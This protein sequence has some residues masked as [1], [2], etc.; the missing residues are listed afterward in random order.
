AEL[1]PAFTLQLLRGLL[2]AAALWAAAPP[3]A[4]FFA[5][6]GAVPVIRAL[7]LVAVLR[8]LANPAV[9]LAVR[10]IEFARVFWW[11][12][13]EGL[14]SF[15]LAV[16]VALIRRD[17]W[18]LV[19]AA[20]GMQLVAA[21]A[22]YALVP[23]RPRLTLRGGRRL[24]RFGGWVSGARTLMFLSVNADNAV[25]GRF[26]GTSALGIY[27]LAFRVS[28]LAVVTVAR[29]AGQVALPALSRLRTA[30]ERGREWGAVLRPVLAACCAYAVAVC[31]LGGPLLERLL[32]PEWRAAVPALRILAVAMVFRAVV[33]VASELFNAAGRPHLALQVNALRLVVM[34]AAIYPLMQAFGLPGV[35][36]AVLLAGL[37]SAA[38]G[39]YLAR[40]LR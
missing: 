7:G 26:L 20:L 5:T 17:V 24:L 36:L 10:R 19:A 16:G 3:V 32:G 40:S 29:A 11:S 21:V 31:L 12:V 2:V 30:A 6:P 8:G 1:D 38:M 22:S 15:T 37:A 14:A 25:V 39:L 9:A 13:P 27:Q 23:R 28:E 34:L 35:A 18:A 33:V 4:S